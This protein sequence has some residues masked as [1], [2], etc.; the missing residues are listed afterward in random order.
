QQD[1]TSLFLFGNGPRPQ[2]AMDRFVERAGGRDA[3]ILVVCWASSL[4]ELVYESIGEQLRTAR[5]HSVSSALEAPDTM[6]ERAQFLEELEQA[7]G[8]FFSGGDQNRTMNA[9]EEMSLGK[10][11]QAKFH[12]GMP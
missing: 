7:T 9:I 12:A 3:R 11:L 8:I 5:A 2:D 4:Q 6:A 1:R 10:A